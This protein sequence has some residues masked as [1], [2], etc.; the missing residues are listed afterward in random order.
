MRE[1]N[2]ES[3]LKKAYFKVYQKDE[4]L[5]E[6]S[7]QLDELAGAALFQENMAQGDNKVYASKIKALV[8]EEFLASA[9]HLATSE[10]IDP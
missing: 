1:R 6:Y 7:A 2:A 3:T 4:M 5:Q 9:K 8:P 10:Y